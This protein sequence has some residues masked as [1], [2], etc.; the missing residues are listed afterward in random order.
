MLG[1]VLALYHSPRGI[2]F[3]LKL[4]E[5]LPGVEADPVRLRQVFHNLIKNAQ[6]AIV[7]DIEGKIIIQSQSIEAGGA[8]YVEILVR[9]NGTG[10][11]PEQV[12][13]VFE[14]YV[15]NKANGTGLGLSI[16]KKIIEEHSGLIWVDPDYRIG[17]GFVIRLPVAKAR[18]RIGSNNRFRDGG[19]MLILQQG[20]IDGFSWPVSAQG[21]AGLAGNGHSPLQEA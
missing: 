11:E 5:Q 13:R 1:E 14:P 9:D 21:K 17:C 12:D 4:G 10:I 18:F 19:R 3:E 16:V 7:G 20:C 8:N 15:T 6:E 2:R